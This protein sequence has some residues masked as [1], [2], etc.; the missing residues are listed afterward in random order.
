MEAPRTNNTYPA[1]L[2]KDLHEEDKDGAKKNKITGDIGPLGDRKVKKTN[3][4]L[5]LPST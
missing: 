4:C 5:F 2:S 1:S 3:K